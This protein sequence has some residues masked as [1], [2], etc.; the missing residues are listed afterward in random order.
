[1]TDEQEQ[2]LTKE[3][4]SDIAKVVLKY[5]EHSLDPDLLAAHMMVA[6]MKVTSANCSSILKAGGLN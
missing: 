1:M 5:A 3:L 2:Q 4:K 6:A